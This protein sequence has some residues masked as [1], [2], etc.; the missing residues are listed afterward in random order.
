M[1]TEQKKKAREMFNDWMEKKFGKETP[2]AEQPSRI[3][4]LVAFCK[5]KDENLKPEKFETATLVDG[6]E[7]TIEP[8]IEPGAAIVLTAEDGT[9]VPA[10]VG[11]YELQDGRIIVVAEDGVV[12]DVREV[13]EEEP[14]G[15]DTPNN[16]EQVKRTIERIEKEKIFTRL[17]ELEKTL[18]EKDKELKFHQ[19][20]NEA[21]TEKFT[22]LESFVKETFETLLEEPSKEP[23]VKKVQ[24]IKRNTESMF[25]KNIKF[26]ENE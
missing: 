22:N 26:K 3:D 24:P 5:D 15:D 13:V 11:E 1:S 23:V 17:E 16:A 25:L 20:N 8:A 4:N 10:P 7:V 2:E 12:A 6:S 18:S 19:E 21:L 14:M 9:P